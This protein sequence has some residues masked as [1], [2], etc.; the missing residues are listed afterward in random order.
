M[1]T[2]ISFRKCAIT[3]RTKQFP[4]LKRKWSIYYQSPILCNHCSAPLDW[5]SKSNQYCNAS[6]SASHTNKNKVKT[7]TS[8]L[9]TSNALKSAYLENKRPGRYIGVKFC[10]CEMCPTTFVINGTD[11]GSTRFCSP[12][13]LSQYRS[14]KMSSWLSIPNNRKNYGRGKQSYM[15]AS[16][17]SWLTECGVIYESE[18]PLWNNTT[19]RNYFVDFFFPH[20]N[21][22]IEL[23]GS[24][25]IKTADKDK[26]RDDFIKQEYGYTILRVSHKEYQSKTKYNLIC[27][28]LNINGTG[29][30]TRTPI[31]PITRL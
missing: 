20:L 26:L 9:K 6:C 19:H 2:S 7:A 16:F 4:D 5:F 14:S 17:S 8:K 3:L 23:D 25:H 11:K 13:C 28:L 27:S 22:V 12:L 31:D 15:E 30:E 29:R 24:Q 10:S 1:S 18:K 21:L